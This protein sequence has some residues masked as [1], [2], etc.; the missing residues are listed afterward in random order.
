MGF[1]LF[2]VVANFLAQYFLWQSCSAWKDLQ[3]DL[4]LVKNLSARRAINSLK[5][6]CT[7][8][9][10]PT[11]LSSNCCD[12]RQLAQNPDNMEC[13]CLRKKKMLGLFINQVDQIRAI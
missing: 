1:R 10:I 7:T 12:T 5:L 11:R 13:W 4:S 3:F 8:G 9:T 2:G 6:N